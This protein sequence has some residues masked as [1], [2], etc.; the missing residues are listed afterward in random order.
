[1]RAPRQQDEGA[2]FSGWRLLGLGFW[3]AWQMISMCTG[4]LVP[5][6]GRFPSAGNALLWVLTLIALG[7]LV[8]MLTAKKHAP[9]L[10]RRAP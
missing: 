1:M 2:R 5:D 6:S 7:F 4:T 3:Q 8:V 9:F 10:A